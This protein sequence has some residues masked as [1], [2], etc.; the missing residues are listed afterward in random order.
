MKWIF[1]RYPKTR[2]NPCMIQ[3]F[4]RVSPVD[5]G[6]FTGE[7]QGNGDAGLLPQHCFVMSVHPCTVYLSLTFQLL[8]H[9]CNVA[10]S[11][12]EGMKSD[13][14]DALKQSHKSRIYFWFNKN[15]YTSLINVK[16][17]G[18]LHHQRLLKQRGC[19]AVTWRDMDV[20]PLTAA[21][22]QIGCHPVDC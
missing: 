7:D 19:V 18:L 1:Y 20:G 17:A 5:D 11:T 14:S 2:G 4:T 12:W 16:W 3:V 10:Q 21:P 8:Y 13:W 22:E 6:S 9:C 15:W